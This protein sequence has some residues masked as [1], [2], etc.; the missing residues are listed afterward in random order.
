MESQAR[1][2]IEAHIADL[3]ESME[4]IKG[5]GSSA[6]FLQQ[7]AQSACVGRISKRLFSAKS[8]AAC[9]DCGKSLVLLDR[10]GGA[11]DAE[12][13]KERKKVR[14]Q[15]AP[16]ADHKIEHRGERKYFDNAWYRAETYPGR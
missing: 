12:A 2:T 7:N 15:Q 9:D 1:T 13:V 3:C 6:Q 10:L 8:H 11:T 14:E 4:G 16:Q 5:G